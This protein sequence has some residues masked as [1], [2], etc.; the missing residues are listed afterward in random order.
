MCNDLQTTHSLLFQ[1]SNTPHYERTKEECKPQ[2]Q[3]IFLTL[4]NFF[5]D[6]AIIPFCYVFE[7]YLEVQTN[8]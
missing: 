3:N 1:L 8:L 5:K 7:N 6:L 4:K 2:S